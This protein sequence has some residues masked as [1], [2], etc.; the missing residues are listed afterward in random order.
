MRLL[1]LVLIAA[2]LA[3]SAARAT[4]MAP[5]FDCAAAASRVEK[6]ICRSDPLKPSDLKRSDVILAALYRDLSGRLDGTTK[7]HLI[8]DQRKWLALR[9]LACFEEDGHADEG[10]P[11]DCLIDVYA[12]RIQ[13]LRDEIDVV[14][15]FTAAGKPPPD[16]EDVMQKPR[17]LYAYYPLEMDALIWQRTY[18]KS[19]RRVPLTCRDVYTL[20]AGKRWQYGSDTVGMNAQG[21]AFSK[22]AMA[23][24]AVENLH[25]KAAP[26]LSDATRYSS[27]LI[28]TIPWSSQWID[29][30]FPR[31]TVNGNAAS[32]GRLAKLGRI[33][34]VTRDKRPVIGY[35]SKAYAHTLV[36]V[37]GKSPEAVSLFLEDAYFSIVLL[38]PGD[39]THC[40][41]VE[42]LM[43]VYIWPSQG[44]LRHSELVLAH[45]DRES[46][47]VRF[48]DIR[49]N[50]GTR[51]K[52]VPGA[53]LAFW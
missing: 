30:W 12:E 22:C 32:F 23:I 10:S 24:V 27:E 11:R 50:M 44:T 45:V 2:W 5:S 33:K 9:D 49:K 18:D 53:D 51:L 31:Y 19:R 36:I 29:E 28:L 14:K 46:G 41:R 35:G 25:P 15:A 52:I 13:E 4:S 40:G 48:Q 21:T 8:E 38:P 34:I 43:W 17:N 6:T 26:A 3:P 39:Y 16:I 47:L 37:N 7:Q 1:P 20:T 42:T